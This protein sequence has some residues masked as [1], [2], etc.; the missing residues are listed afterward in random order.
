MKMKKMNSTVLLLIFVSLSMAQD[1]KKILKDAMDLAKQGKYQESI[2]LFNKS[3]EIN[4]ADYYAHY[5]RGLAK[6][7][8]NYCEDA[9]KDFN[10]T[11]MLSAKY[12]KTYAPRAAAKKGLTDYEGAV[13]DYT[14][15]ITNEPKNGELYFSRGNVNQLLGN[16]DSACADFAKALKLGR[17]DEN[18]KLEKCKDD[19][20]DGVKITPV[21][22]LT[23]NAEDHKYG[24]SEKNPIKVGTGYDGGPS[25]EED[26]IN[27][28]RDVKG[29]PI[30][31]QRLG[32]CC[33]YDSPNGFNGKATL[34][35]YRIVYQVDKDKMKDKE[36]IIYFTMFDYEEPKILNGF[37][38]VVYPQK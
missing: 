16:K 31:F 30:Y 37:S 11:L 36:S 4:P 8:M 18:K 1:A 10:S 33:V 12:K 29:W 22:R 28:L 27:L 9:L 20:Y 32:T 38:T 17:K 19:K 6:L 25:N 34:D 15:A 2:P 26:Y 3:I 14:E 5:N 21:F 7:K 23:K 13:A 24:F 35:K